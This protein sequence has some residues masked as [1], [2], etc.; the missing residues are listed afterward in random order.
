MF[1]WG[2]IFTFLI[3][4]TFAYGIGFGGKF[5]IEDLLKQYKAVVDTCP[6]KVFAD[7]LQQIHLPNDNKKYQYH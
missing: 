4:S 5:K 3:L 1:D 7:I 6:N 2:V